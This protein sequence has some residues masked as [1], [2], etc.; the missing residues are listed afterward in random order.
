LAASNFGTS[1]AS[2]ILTRDTVAESESGTI[3]SSETGEVMGFQNTAF[4]IELGELSD[5]EFEER[6]ALVEAE[7]IANPDHE[8]H[9]HRKLGKKRNN[10]CKCNKIAYDHG[11]IRE[12]DL[13]DIVR[14]CDGI[15]TVNVRRGW[16]DLYGEEDFDTTQICGPGSVVVKKGTRKKK[17]KAGTKQKYVSDQ[18]TFRTRKGVKDKSLTFSCRRGDCYA[19]G[20][21]ILQGLGESC[22]VQRDYDGASECEEGLVCYRSD[23]ETFGVGTCTKLQQY[24]KSTQVCQIDFGV[25][26]CEAGY[27]CYETNGLKTKRTV[28]TIHTGNCNRVVKRAAHMEV[29]DVSHG[30]DA[31]V[32]GYV[33]LGVN[34]REIRGKKGLGY[35]AARVGRTTPNLNNN[36]VGWYVDYEFHHCVRSCN[37]GPFCGGEAENWEETWDT[38][39]RC[40]EGQLSWMKRSDCIPDYVWSGRYDWDY[41]LD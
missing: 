31:C 14:R 16:K 15:N 19:S 24:A 5:E 38:A 12:R 4:T 11:K 35:C 23:G 32:N 6:R 2:A 1:W 34:G 21:A 22:L 9:H 27:A 30:A 3:L 39:V 28:G 25:N 37:N 41:Y 40:C 17:N 20:G 36:R 13:E 29:C 7:M 33:C 8:D 10:P 26:A 18:V